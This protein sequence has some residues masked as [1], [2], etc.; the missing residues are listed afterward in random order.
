MSVSDSGTAFCR[1][2]NRLLII[3]FCFVNSLM[4]LTFE[5][6]ELIEYKAVNSIQSRGLRK[7]S[8]NP[9]HSKLSTVVERD[10][11]ASAL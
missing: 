3:C 7:V 8:V 10:C 9:I 2:E 5:S 4:K 1:F 6:K 11:E